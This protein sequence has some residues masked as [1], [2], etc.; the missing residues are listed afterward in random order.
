MKTILLVLTFFAYSF[1]YEKGYIDT[2]GGK[3]DSL[4]K[5]KGFSN[6]ISDEIQVL[7]GKNIKKEKNTQL[8]NEEKLINKF[9]E[10]KE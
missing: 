10:G 2:H 7:N 1:S 3:S 8:D 9:L 6:K 4:I 5:N